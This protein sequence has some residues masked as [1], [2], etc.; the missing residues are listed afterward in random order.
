V[1]VGTVEYQPLVAKTLLARANDPLLPYTHVAEAYRGCQLRCEFC[2]SRSLSE[3]VGDEPKTFVRRVSVARNAAEVL[4][5]E[6]A[7]ASMQPRG[8]RVICIGSESDPYQP[9]E[10]RFEVTRDML[11]V[12]LEIEHPV[13]VQTR[14]ELVLRDLDVMEALADRGLVNVMISMQTST[15]G[16]RNKVELGTASVAE[17]FRTMRMLAMKNVPVGLLLSPIMPEL[18]DDEAVLDETARRAR[19]AGAKWIV[20]QVL[21]LRGSAAV[22]VP[23]FLESFTPALVERYETFYSHGEKGRTADPEYLKR[24]TEEVV[25][26]LATKYGLDDYSQMLTSGHEPLACL[27]R[28]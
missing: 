12:C 26:A 6:L 5:R 19:D 21:D 4:A 14:Q 16:I 20:A 7:E 22:K 25:P 18:T 23:L 24:M 1:G 15:E 10:E 8:E 13:I 11:K 9:A 27:V 17:R 28:R 3:W 2:H